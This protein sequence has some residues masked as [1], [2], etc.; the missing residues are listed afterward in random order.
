MESTTAQFAKAL[1]QSDFESVIPLLAADCTY[2]I[3][4]S[5]LS[6]I[7]AIIASYQEADEWGKKNLDDVRYESKVE[8]NAITFIDFLS[9]KGKSHLHQCQQ[10]TTMN[11]DGLICHIEHVELRGERE[12]VDEF[13]SSVGVVR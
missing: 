8:G 6:G 2:T 1:D 3:S 7:E 13:F 4:G 5:T 9:H 11:A 12:Q 10:I